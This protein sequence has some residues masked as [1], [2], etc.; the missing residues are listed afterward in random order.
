MGAFFEIVR[1]EDKEQI[2]WSSFIEP[3]RVV[4]IHI[5]SLKDS[6]DLMITLRYCRS[7]EGVCVHQPM[8]F[9]NR[10]NGFAKKLK[11]TLEG[12]SSLIGFESKGLM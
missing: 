5:V 4:P 7:S 11:R 8:K 6:L 12:R 1:H 3:G 2:L 9:A 10:A